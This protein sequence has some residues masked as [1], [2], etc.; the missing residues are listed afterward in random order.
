[1]ERSPVITRHFHVRMVSL[2]FILSL[3]DAYFLSSSIEPY[4]DKNRKKHLPITFI[5]FAFE[6][7]F[8]A[9]SLLVMFLKWAL[10]TVDSQR[11]TPWE[12]KVTIFMLSDLLVSLFK[13]VLYLMYIYIMIDALTVP[14]F[15]IRPF[16]YTVR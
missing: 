11:E 1:M 16:Y 10:H 8:L 13:V 12:K 6:Y 5:V 14:L 2:M 15:V 7:I 4:T 9:I 3:A